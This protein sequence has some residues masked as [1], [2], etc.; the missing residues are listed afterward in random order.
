VADAAVAGLGIAMLP[1]Y[2]CRE[3]LAEG[4]LVRVLPEWSPQTRY[5]TQITAVATPERMR[6]SRNRALL[7]FLR[8]RFE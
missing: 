6:L 8:Q 4:R 7:E 2:L 3:A 1:D 5:G